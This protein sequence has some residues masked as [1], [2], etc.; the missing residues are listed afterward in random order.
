MSHEPPP[1]WFV[2]TITSGIQTLACLGLPG[3]PPADV[4]AKTSQVWVRAVWASP[5]RWEEALDRK[6]LG[7]GFASLVISTD[8]WP[9]PAAYLR[10]IPR[11][12][13]P[14]ALPAPSRRTP[15]PAAIRAKLAELVASMRSGG[16]R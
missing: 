5:L 1:P 10:A 8:R 6:R 14:P 13:Q 3:A 4:L 12:P 7:E 9:A 15:M 2:N 16:L 11:R